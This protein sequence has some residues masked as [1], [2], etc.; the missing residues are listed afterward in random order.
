[1]AETLSASRAIAISRSANTQVL[2]LATAFVCIVAGMLLSMLFARNGIVRPI[3]RLTGVMSNL[4]AGK[5][6]DEIPGTD[7]K[8]EIGAMARTLD[9][10]RANEMQMREMEAQEAALQAQSKDLQSNISTI[11]AAAAAGDFSR[12]ITKSY[13]DE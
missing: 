9:V 6:D 12:R 10:F 4:A 8:D 3:Q 13:E 7:R 2:L 5:L 11:V 1:S